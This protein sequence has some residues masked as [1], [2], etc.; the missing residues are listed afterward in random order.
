MSLRGRLTLLYTSLVGG[1]LLLFGIAIYFTVS[2][3]LTTQITN[4]LRSTAEEIYSNARVDSVGELSVIM[5]P[6]LDVP[7]D[8]F[9]QVWSHN[10]KL[11]AASPN[12]S[13]LDQPLDVRGLQSTVP[14]ERDV[15]LGSSRYRVLTVPLSI[16]GS[17]RVVGTLQVGIKTDVVTQTQRTLLAVLVVGTILAIIAAGL[18]GWFAT[19]QALSPLD[20][21]TEAA[22]QITRA[23]DL[24]RRIP[25][26]GSPEDE[27]G[28]LINAFNQTLS[29][30]ETLFHTQRR[31][32]ADDG[33]ELRTPLRSSRGTLVVTPDGDVDDESW[34]ASRAR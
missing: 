12:I 33:H 13:Y 30:L 16:T 21:V 6:N 25:Y 3:T 23:E 19:S 17:E 32:L 34:A 2:T 4:L 31:F 29:R 20:S 9:V 28:Q 8:V 15:T 18:T 27:I 14:H 7:A 24:S 26:R 10:N 11:R 22:L 5:L 1:I